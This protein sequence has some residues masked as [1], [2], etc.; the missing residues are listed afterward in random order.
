MKRETALISYNELKTQHSGD[1]VILL[2][3]IGSTVDFR[4]SLV[5][6]LL[7]PRREF[8]EERGLL[9][10]TAAGNRVYLRSYDVHLS[11]PD[12]HAT[13]GSQHCRSHAYLFCVLS[14]PTDFRGKERLLPVYCRVELM[15]WSRTESIVRCFAQYPCPC[16]FG[17]RKK[18]DF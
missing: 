9:S 13:S 14:V 7:S 8:G 10:R 11:P 18:K 5:S 3:D 12:A 15:Q 6:G 1:G 4:R 16:T 17:I 2:V